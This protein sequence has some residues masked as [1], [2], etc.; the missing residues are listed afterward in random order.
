[1]GTHVMIFKMGGPMHSLFLMGGG[2]GMQQQ[3]LFSWQMDPIWLVG[4]KTTTFFIPPWKMSIHM[5]N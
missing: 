4:L 1:M 2:E 5:V 3:I